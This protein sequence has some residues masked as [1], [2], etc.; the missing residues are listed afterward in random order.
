[1]ATSAYGPTL[2]L[3]RQKT[4][5]CLAPLRAIEQAQ[6]VWSR[7]TNEKRSWYGL[8]PGKLAREARSAHAR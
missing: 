8:V 4:L 5:A 3:P 6:S 1:M 2:A 7:W